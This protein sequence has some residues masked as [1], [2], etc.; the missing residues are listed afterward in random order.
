MTVIPVRLEMDPSLDRIQSLGVFAD[1]K[2][3]TDE[4]IRFV[5]EKARFQTIIIGVKKAEGGGWKPKL[6]TGSIVER[7]R[8][9]QQAG[10]E[11][12]VMP[13]LVRNV[14]A[15]E[16]VCEWLLDNFSIVDPSI[17]D[18]EEGAYTGSMAPEA[19]AEMIADM[20]DGRMWGV[21]SIGKFP[22]TLAALIRLARILCP[23]GYSF[24][25]PGS[26]AHWSHS[27]ST[28]PGPQQD[29]AFDEWNEVNDSARFAMGLGCYWDDRPAQGLTPALTHH[30]MRFAA[31]E[32]AALGIVEAWYWSL[33]WML[34]EGEQG[35]E[36]R[37]FFGIA[38]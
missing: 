22:P 21:T 4:E 31:I 23:M 18:A 33:K 14:H 6:E 1:W 37:T 24:W 25:K 36:V 20:L 7:V 35:E 32:T 10:L 28:F 38:A 2:L 16:S 30:T 5:A 29:E 3:P 12:F 9:C 26:A 27:R 15:V 8:A 17:F 34:R 11:T 13:W 19:M